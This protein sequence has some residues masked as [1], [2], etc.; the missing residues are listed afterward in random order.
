MRIRFGC[1]LPAPLPICAWVKRARN[2]RAWRSKMKETVLSMFGL[3]GAAHS[4]RKGSIGIALL[5]LCLFSVFSL[6]PEAGAGP[7]GWVWMSGSNLPNQPGVYGTLGTP[8]AAN[9]PGWRTGAVSWTDTNGNLWLFGGVGISSN[10]AGGLN[11]LW[12]F[13]PSTKEWTWMGGSDT[14]DQPGVYGTRGTPAAANV[15][16]AR[17][18]ASSWTDNNGNF[19]LFGGYGY[20]VNGNENPLNDLW[21]FNPSTK[22]WTW[23]AGSRTNSQNGVYG[24]LGVFAAANVPGARGGAAS[25]ADNSGHFWLFGGGFQNDLWEFD[26]SKVEWA[27]MGGSSTVPGAGWVSGVYG[28]L[29]M[30]AAG[31]VPGT[32]NSAVTWTDGNGNLWLFGGLGYGTSTS[33]YQGFL[34]DLWEFNPATNEWAW[35]GG[36]NSFPGSDE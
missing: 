22:Q 13:N 16:G 24:T 5:C 11:D 31:N 4:R 36:G 20:D 32:R 3:Q 34:N 18:P 26:P 10:F 7:S 1:R 14:H 27:W 19:W 6:P 29:G 35:M 9:V 21:E 23:I 28:T 25:W 30:P 33:I 17:T 2:L 12:E 8:A 15:P